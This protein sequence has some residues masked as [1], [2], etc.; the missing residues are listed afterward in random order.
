MLVTVVMLAAAVAAAER[1]MYRRCGAQTSTKSQFNKRVFL[2]RERQK[3]CVCVSNSGRNGATNFTHTHDLIAIIQKKK[4]KIN[5][6]SAHICHFVLADDQNNIPSP[7]PL[8]QLFL[9][10]VRSIQILFSCF[11]LVF[12]QKKSD[13]LWSAIVSL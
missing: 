8:Q 11:K 2:Q 5:T 3:V 6:T 10:V 4:Y 13:C 7:P 12:S 1:S 9:F